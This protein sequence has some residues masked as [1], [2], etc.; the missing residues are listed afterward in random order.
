MANDEV[1]E[2][3]EESERL[4]PFMV[5]KSGAMVWRLLSVVVDD[6]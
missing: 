3:V 5:A 6:S 1:N 2:P 4:S